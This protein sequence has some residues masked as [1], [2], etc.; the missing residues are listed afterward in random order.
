[1]VASGLKGF[2]YG[3]SRENSVGVVEATS[4]RFCG[5]IA[6]VDVI[7]EYAV[8]YPLFVALMRYRYLSSA[9]PWVEILKK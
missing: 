1:M 5:A 2:G 8:V 9:L 4:P 3:V 6:Q 7:L